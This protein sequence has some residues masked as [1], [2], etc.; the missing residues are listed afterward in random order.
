M[1]ITPERV[2]NA[3]ADASL[4]EVSLQASTAL[5]VY[6]NLLHRWNQRLNLTSIRDEEEV[7]SRHIVEGIFVAQALPPI[8]GTLLDFGSG[9]GIPGIIIAVCRPDLRV[10]LA[11][12]KKKKASFLK[13]ATRCMCL[14]A[15][16]HAGR[17]EDLAP[18]RCFEFITM[19]AVDRMPQMVPVAEQR[20]GKAGTLYLLTSTDAVPTLQSSTTQAMHWSQIPLP[21]SLSRLLLIGRQLNVPRGTE[22]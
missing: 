5:S 22:A 18:D 8:G 2:S 7:L 16:V 10:V 9:T 19:R 20:L 14:S 12:A 1:S 3:I 11:E 13:E 6:A 17:V 21:G 15:T 4:A